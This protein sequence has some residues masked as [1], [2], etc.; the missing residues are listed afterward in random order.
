MVEVIQLQ[1]IAVENMHLFT[2]YLV[3]RRKREQRGDWEDS[4]PKTK[5]L[6]GREFK[7][8]AR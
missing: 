8:S 3:R 7:R 6:R 5:L 1:Y 4:L 2:Q